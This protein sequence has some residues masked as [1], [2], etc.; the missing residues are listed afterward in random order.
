VLVK[1]DG[2][3]ARLLKAPDEREPQ[4]PAGADRVVPVASVGAVGEPLTAETVHRPERVA[5]VTGA[6]VGD[7]ITPELV[8]RVLADERGGLKDV[9]PDATAIPLIN[10]VDDDADEAVARAV[11]RVVHERADASRVD[12]PR[13]VLARMIDGAV[14][15]VV[16]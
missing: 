4:V 1:A 10:A 8:G 15:D 14:V 6:A 7:E 3:R 16:E 11:A 12:V 13:V 9:P 2:A 5:A